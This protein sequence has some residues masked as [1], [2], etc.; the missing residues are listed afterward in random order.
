MLKKRTFLTAILSVVLLAACQSNDGAESDGNTNQ[1]NEDNIEETEPEKP[2]NNADDETEEETDENSDSDNEDN[3]ESSNQ[4][5]EQVSEEEYASVHE[6]MDA[7]EDY[8]EIEQTNTDLGYG[9]EAMVEGAAGH[10]YISWNEGRWLIQIDFPS[11]PQYKVDEYEDGE[12]MAKAIVEYLEDNTLP[13]PTSQGVIR[14]EA[15]SDHPKTSIRWQ[16]DATVYE[17]EEENSDPIDTL[18]IAVDFQKQR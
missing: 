10:Q 2:D 11:D 13:A 9:I 18:Q 8:Q 3:S 7:I 12:S 5:S 15:F 1:T 14:I 6:A 17:I 16:E 4:E